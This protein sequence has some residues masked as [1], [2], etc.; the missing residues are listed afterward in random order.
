M[1]GVKCTH[2]TTCISTY[3]IDM[4]QHHEGIPFARWVLFLIQ[5]IVNKLGCIRDEVVKV[6]TT[7]N[8]TVFS[9]NKFLGG[10][11]LNKPQYTYL[12]VTKK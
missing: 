3:T 7:I 1:T 8:H 2:V 5:V 9:Y 6:P 4:N 10:E 12:H 11:K